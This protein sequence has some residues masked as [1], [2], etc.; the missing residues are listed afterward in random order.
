MNKFY[1]FCEHGNKCAFLKKYANFF[2]IS[3]A[4]TSY[5]HFVAK[6]MRPQNHYQILNNGF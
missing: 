1:M 3:A 6:K 5:G 4:N 2:T